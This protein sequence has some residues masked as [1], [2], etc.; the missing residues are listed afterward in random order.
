MLPNRNFDLENV[1]S[2]FECFFFVQNPAH[3]ICV[4]VD[5]AHRPYVLHIDLCATNIGV[6]LYQ[7]VESGR[8]ENHKKQNRVAILFDESRR[9]RERQKKK[10]QERNNN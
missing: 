6:Y 9:W 1:L 5:N 4:G 8:K 2:L 10:K 7:N 3:Y